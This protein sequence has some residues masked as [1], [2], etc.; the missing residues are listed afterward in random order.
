MAVE[1]FNLHA[2]VM[3]ASATDPDQAVFAFHS[4]PYALSGISPNRVFVQSEVWYF[5]TGR[6]ADAK[7]MV[8]ETKI[9]EVLGTNIKVARLQAPASKV[10]EVLDTGY[11]RPSTLQGQRQYVSTSIPYIL[12]IIP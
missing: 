6:P 5:A 1:V 7:T 2:Y 4:V 10:Y 12:E 3:E 9:Y 11:G 8:T